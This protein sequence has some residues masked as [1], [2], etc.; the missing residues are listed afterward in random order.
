[1]LKNDVRLGKKKLVTKKVSD[2]LH[3]DLVK[4][5]VLQ[6]RLKASKSFEDLDDLALRVPER[7]SRVLTWLKSLGSGHSSFAINA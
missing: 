4:L 6:R 2:L 3:V 1:M 5:V 7:N